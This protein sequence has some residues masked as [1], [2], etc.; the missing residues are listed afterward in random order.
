MQ[1]FTMLSANDSHDDLGLIIDITVDEGARGQGIGK[2]LVTAMIEEARKQGA[3]MLQADVWRGSS[4]GSL[5]EKAGVPLVKSVHELRLAD[6]RRGQPRLHR[7]GVF[8]DKLL[9][10]LTAVLAIIV[11]AFVFGG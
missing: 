5:L 1:R 2:A 8:F 10:W 9:P 7:I 11:L 4:S 3:T 6:A